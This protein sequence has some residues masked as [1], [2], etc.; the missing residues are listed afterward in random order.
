MQ[1]SD[2]YLSIWVF[3]ALCIGSLSGYLFPNLSQF[4][5]GL[6]LSRINLPNSEFYILWDMIFPQ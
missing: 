4:I 5:G 6:E 2:R 1:F 3:L